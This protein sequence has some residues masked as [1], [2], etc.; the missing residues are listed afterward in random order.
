[1]EPVWIWSD[2]HYYHTKVIEYENRP[3]YREGFPD[4]ESMNKF[5]SK[6]WRETVKDKQKIFHLGDFC[7][8]QNKQDVEKIIKNQPG[9]KILILGNHDR[10]KSV[11]WWGEVGFDEVYPYPIIYN[12]F[13]I[14][15][16]E[17]VYLN[18]HM[19][20]VNIH[21]H[22]HSNKMDNENYVNVCVENINYKPIDLNIIIKRFEK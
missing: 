20:Y 19:P 22:L 16:H 3:F 17:P 18:E 9:Y 5:L 15:S 21:G 4:I 11:K 13:F 7:F 2:S 10:C 8:K 1:M 14:L 12:N 6:N